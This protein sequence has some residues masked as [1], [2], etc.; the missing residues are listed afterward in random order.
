MVTCLSKRKGSHSAE[1]KSV[2]FAL[3]FSTSQKK[4]KKKKFNFRGFFFIRFFSHIFIE[5]KNIAKNVLR[6]YWQNSRKNIK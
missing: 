2:V 4:K 5:K 3:Q 6:K 1:E